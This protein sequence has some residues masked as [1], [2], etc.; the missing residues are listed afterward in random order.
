M[1]KTSFFEEAGPTFTQIDPTVLANFA[2]AASNS[3]ANANASALAAA[4]SLAAMAPFNG[5]PLING[6][7]AAGVSTLFARGDHVHPI[8][9]SRAAVT[10]VDTQ[11]ALRLLKTSNLSDLANAATAR[12]NLGL[13]TS[14][15]INTGTSGAVIPLLNGLNSW[16]A[17]QII[18]DTTASTGATTGALRVT[19]GGGFG[20][21]VSAGKGF[22]ATGS[23]ANAS[24]FRAPLSQ[25]SI[26]QSASAAVAPAAQSYGLIYVAEIQN[27]GQAALFFVTF[28]AAILI[29]QTGTKW[30]VTTT[31]SAGNFGFSYNGT[32]HAIYNNQGVS[33]VFQ[34][35]LFAAI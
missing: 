32:Q 27:T 17:A 5:S 8:D 13:G 14:A 23:S 2:S 31:P 11:D 12:S 16:S 34:T 35:L 24:H 18:T 7:A 4:A 21:A 1:A 3:A 33:C 30:S 29:S 6:T 25:F 26:A 22:L 9:T 20:D 19:G 10:Y 15:T 28:G